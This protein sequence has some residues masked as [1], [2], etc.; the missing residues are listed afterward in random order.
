MG[1]IYK[2]AWPDIE[3]SYS[4]L[5]LRFQLL[6]QFF[7]ENNEILII[8]PDKNPTFFSKVSGVGGIC[9][10]VCAI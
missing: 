2:P 8:Y 7:L 10:T 5:S 1:I 3:Y 9:A 4:I 6:F